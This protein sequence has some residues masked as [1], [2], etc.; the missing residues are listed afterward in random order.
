[1]LSKQLGPPLTECERP[2]YRLRDVGPVPRRFLTRADGFFDGLA[3]L[4]LSNKLI[5]RQVAER[6]VQAALL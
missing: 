3:H 2:E 6:V 1:M 5:R 4:T